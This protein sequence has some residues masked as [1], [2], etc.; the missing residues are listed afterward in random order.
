I[1]Q[2]LSGECGGGKSISLIDVLHRLSSDKVDESVGKLVIFWQLRRRVP[3]F[4]TLLYVEVG[5]GSQ[6]GVFSKSKTSNFVELLISGQYVSFSHLDINT[7]LSTLELSWV[8]MLQSCTQSATFNLTNFSR[9][10]T[11]EGNSIRLLHL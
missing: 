3:P 5:G 11:Y 4:W 8:G 1:S 7:Y 10:P 2:I 6:M 9:F